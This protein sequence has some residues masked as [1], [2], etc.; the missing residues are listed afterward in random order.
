MYR[1]WPYIIHHLIDSGL[2][3][4]KFLEVYLRSVYEHARVLYLVTPIL[5]PEAD[6]NHYL[7][8]N[9]GLRYLSCMFPE[10]RDAEVWKEHALHEMELKHSC[11]GDRRRRTDRRL[12][13]LS[14]WKYLLVCIAGSA[15]QA[16]WL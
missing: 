14:Q 1:T 8:E 9:N 16:V 13:I 2:I 12:C 11:T 15:V 3:D 5:W 6:H 4:E 7:M 10:L